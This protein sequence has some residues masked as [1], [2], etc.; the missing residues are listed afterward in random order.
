MPGSRRSG[1]FSR[2]LE[3]WISGG[4]Q[5]ARATKPG[6]D[7][8]GPIR[9][10]ERGDAGAHHS[11]GRMPGLGGGGREI[12]EETITVAEF[13]LGILLGTWPPAGQ[14]G[15]HACPHSLATPPRG[16]GLLGSQK[17]T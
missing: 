13:I 6:I 12:D 5:D 2:S 11:Q 16:P 7:R 8:V 4:T 9:A 14:L 3:V 15:N 10:F 1:D 17:G